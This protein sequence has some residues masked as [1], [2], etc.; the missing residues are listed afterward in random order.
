[1][2]SGIPCFSGSLEL[3]LVEMLVKETE[4]NAAGGENDY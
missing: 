2:E 4:A 1:L 3:A